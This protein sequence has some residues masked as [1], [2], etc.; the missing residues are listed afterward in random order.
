M[1]KTVAIGGVTVCF[2]TPRKLPKPKN[3]GARV[4]VLDIAFASESGGSSNAFEKTTL[5]FIEEL[6]P[7]LVAWVD[8]HDSEHHARFAGDPRFV[9]ARKAQHGACPEMITPAMVAAAGPVDT[10]VCHTD[11]DG[12]ASAAKWL[13]GGREPYPGNDADARAI[14][15]RTGIPSETAARMDRAL[16]ARS[17]DAA[18]ESAVVAVLHAGL[19]DDAA[20]AVIDAAGAELVPREAESRRLA[21]GYRQVGGDVVLVDVGDK[22]VPYDRTLL[23]LLGQERARISAVVDGDNVT[24]AAPFDSGV[25][26]LERFGLSGGMPTMVSLHKSKLDSALASLGAGGVP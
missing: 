19:R 21:G 14:D 6:G 11:F 17:R 10:I 3:L 22:A 24:F 8:H 7:R 18:V 2:G 16:R 9:L 12:L 25:N 4:V 13:L 5:R 15:T 1:D 23:L 20:W 26:F